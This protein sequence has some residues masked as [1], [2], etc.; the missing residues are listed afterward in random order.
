[1][2]IQGIPIELETGWLKEA[3]G[4]PKEAVDFAERL[5]QILVDI[6]QNG[7]PGYNQ[8]TTSQV[9]NFFG[10]M[11]RIQMKGFEKNKGAFHMLKPKLAYAVA[12]AGRDSK[13]KVFQQVTNYLME[14]VAD[15]AT[16]N[17]FIAF[18]EAVV[19]YHKSNGGKD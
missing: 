8:M 9:R 14:G 13:I 11:R 5:G 17:N 3:N 7:R 10:E 6:G 18:M 19:A 15:Q 12:R 2:K 1:M 4:L 16:Y